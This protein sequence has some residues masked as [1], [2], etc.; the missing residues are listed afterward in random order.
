MVAGNRKHE[1]VK[2]E[3]VELGVATLADKR[4]GF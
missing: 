1:P 4:I 2:P 3:L